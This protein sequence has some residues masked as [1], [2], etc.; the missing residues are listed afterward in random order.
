MY[1]QNLKNYS[2]DLAAR[3][4]APGGGSAAAA[5]ANLGAALLSM[6]ANYTIGKPAYDKYEDEMKRVLESSEKLRLEFLNLVDLDVTAFKSKDPRQAMD[7]PMMVCRLCYEGIKLCPALAKKGNVNLISDVAVAA[8]ML[9]AAY[10]SAYY[11]VLINLKY[12]DDQKLAVKVKKELVGKNE[13]MKR[14]RQATEVYIGK[15]IGG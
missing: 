9:E 12:L 13:K 1:A 10:A 2:D 3:I 8:A 11:N 4:P 15:I 5:C 7:V 14:F 6:V